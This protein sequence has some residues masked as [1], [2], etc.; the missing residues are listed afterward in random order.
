MAVVLEFRSRSAKLLADQQ[1]VID[2]AD[3]MADGYKESAKEAGNLER[4]AKRLAAQL[5]TPQ[6]RHNRKLKELSTLLKTGRIDQER[7]TRAV[8]M[9]NRELEEAKNKGKQAFGAGSLATL[10]QFAAGILGIHQVSQKVVQSLQEFID[11]RDE[12]AGRVRASRAGM[13]ELLQLHLRNPA[14][15]QAALAEAR[16]AFAM[17]AT[18]SEDEA[19]GLIFNLQSAGATDEDRRMFLRLGAMGTVRSPAALAEAANTFRAAFG[20]DAQGRQ[21]A[22]AFRTMLNQGFAAAGPGQGTIEELFRGAAFAAGGATAVGVSP[23]ELLA[24]V[25]TLSTPAGGSQVAGNRLANFFKSA[26]RGGLSGN[27][28]SIVEQVSSRRA[29]GDDFADIFGGSRD[30]EA[31]QGFRFLRGNLPMLRQLIGE[32]GTADQRDLVGSAMT[33]ADTDPQLRAARIHQRVIQTGQVEEQARF[34]AAANLLTAAQEDLATRMRVE[35]GIEGQLGNMLRDMVIR[36]F[37]MFADDET[38]LRQFR[39]DFSVR[40]PELSRAIDDLLSESKRQTDALQNIERNQSG[41]PPVTRVKGRA[42]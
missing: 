10:S 40:D 39:E 32:V 29:A 2:Q 41:K 8:D 36:G 42:E 33:I 21:I 11:K 14:G 9:Y 35:H 37:R 4:V 22:P 3:K 17:G 15:G 20:V 25:G 5:E 18:S 16:R 38:V 28:L 26:E 23:Q 27:L 19:G 13:S 24:A 7:M 30:F 12:A 31:I 1:K 34:G 6:E